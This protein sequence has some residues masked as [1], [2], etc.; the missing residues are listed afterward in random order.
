MNLNSADRDLKTMNL[1]GIQKAFDESNT[2]GGNQNT[3][4]KHVN[5]ANLSGIEQAFDGINTFFINLNSLDMN[6]DKANPNTDLNDDTGFN[7]D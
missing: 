4:E 7:K 5:T 6:L 2:V 3:L 1:T